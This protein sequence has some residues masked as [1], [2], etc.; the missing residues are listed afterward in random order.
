[1]EPPGGWS[2]PSKPKIKGL[3]YNCGEKGH[4]SH[5]R[6]Y[7][8]APNPIQSICGNCGQQEHT[9]IECHNPKQPRLLVKYVYN[10]PAKEL[11]E[12]RLIYLESTEHVEVMN[13]DAMK[14]PSA[15]VL[16]TSTRSMEKKKH[17]ELRKQMA[18]G[19]LKFIKEH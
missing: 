6:P 15:D 19:K 13:C 5:V 10:A 9:P 12:V 16:K 3:C 18:K 14:F 8:K 2:D 1:M 11:T 17:K 4:Y 7:P